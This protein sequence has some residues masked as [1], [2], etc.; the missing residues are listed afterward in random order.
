M[1]STDRKSRVRV[2]AA[3][4]AGIA[5]LA[6]A[7]CGGSSNSSSGI[8]AAVAPNPN[9]T[10]RSNTGTGSK[11]GTG[12]RATVY[13]QKSS[14]PASNS[15][16]PTT[17]SKATIKAA[18]PSPGASS[19]SASAAAASSKDP[20]ALVTQSEIE[21]IAHEK[22][23]R[24]TNAPLGPTCVI[25]LAGGPKTITVAIA[26]ADVSS[27]VKRMPRKPVELTLSGRRA[28]CGVLGKPLLSVVLGGGYALQISA[29]CSLA[30][31]LARKA[32]PRIAA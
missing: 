12:V 11:T 32:L 2:G 7:G 29:P 27:L 23:L 17:Q 28:Y 13:Q 26:A 25:Q 1:T 6:I 3:L 5:A 9:T 31:S 22:V 24:L 19:G 8:T 21:A 14:K 20:C 4:A 15:M 18:T 30:T 16:A 10:S